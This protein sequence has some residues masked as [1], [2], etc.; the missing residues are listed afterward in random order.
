VSGILCE[1][2]Q[3]IFADLIQRLVVDD[4]CIDQYVFA[5]D[6]ILSL[7][8]IFFV[9]CDSSLIANARQRA[10][11]GTQSARASVVQ[12]GMQCALQVSPAMLYMSTAA[13]AAS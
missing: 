4:K 9:W 3:P 10:N 6:W 12:S 1:F 7:C 2:M 8:S 11:F 5:V 13:L